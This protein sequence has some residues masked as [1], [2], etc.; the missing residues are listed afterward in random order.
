MGWKE[1]SKPFNDRVVNIRVG[2][3]NYFEN[4][5]VTFEKALSAK[6]KH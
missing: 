3:I 2:E 1:Y 5:S 6:R 4:S